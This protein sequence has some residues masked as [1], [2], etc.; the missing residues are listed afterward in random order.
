MTLTTAKWR[1]PAPAAPPAMPPGAARNGEICGPL[2]PEDLQTVRRA[3]GL[4]KFIL[5][6]AKTAHG[7]GMTTLLIG[8]LAL[9]CSVMSP[10]ATTLLIGLALTVLGGFELLM[11][12]RLA[13]FH[14]G[15][16]RWL[17]CNQLVL[18]AVVAAYCISQM[19]AYDAQ[20][21]KNALLSPQVRSLGALPSLTSRL[22][23]MVDRWGAAG[24][25]GF[26]GLVILV[27]AV[28]QGGLAWRYL[29]RR[30]ALQALHRDTPAWVDRLLAQLQR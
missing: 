16:P 4:R 18:L 1:G 8:L 3:E 11:G 20:A 5:K 17:A 12:W 21:I 23:S 19:A 6:G 13:H 27:S 14:R 22:D 30:K 28:F 29:K 2:S 7:S 15:A 10:G 26:Y 24:T 25:Y 9:A